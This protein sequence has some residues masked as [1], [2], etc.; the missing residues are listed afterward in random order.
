[1]DYKNLG[2][3]H[4]IPSYYC[5]LFTVVSYPS[6]AEMVLYECFIKGNRIANATFCFFAWKTCSFF[7]FV[8][9]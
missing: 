3:I 4:L 2:I 5:P 6:I 9:I 1:M 8:L 7:S